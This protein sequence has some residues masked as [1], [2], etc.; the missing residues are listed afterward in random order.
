M[1]RV[2]PALAIDPLNSVVTGDT[3]TTLDFPVHSGN[4]SNKAKGFIGRLDGRYRQVPL[5]TIVL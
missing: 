3:N 4:P 2:E 1:A 5:H